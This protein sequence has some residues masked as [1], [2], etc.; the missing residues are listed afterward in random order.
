MRLAAV[1]ASAALFPWSGV[2]ASAAPQSPTEAAVSWLRDVASGKAEA[3]LGEETALSPEASPEDVKGVR[4]QL[5]RLRE[6]LKPDDLRPLAD[7][8]DGDLAA[9]LISQITNFDANSLQIHAVGLVRNKD[10][11]WVPAPMPSSFASTGLSLRP[12]FLERLKMM[13]SWMSVERSDQLVRLKADIF[14]LLTEE[15]RKVVTPATLKDSTPAKLATDFLTALAKRDMPTALALAGG[16]EDPRPANWDDTFQV[17]SSMLRRKEITHS[18]WRLL[19]APDAVRVI[20]QVDDNPAEPLVSIVGLDPAGSAATPRPRAVHLPLVRS[21]TGTWRVRLTHDLLAPATRPRSPGQ[22]DE[23]KDFD[24]EILAKFPAK[25]SE[26]MPPVPAATA[27][28]A[29]LA[30]ESALSK[31]SVAD[32]CTRLDLA[33]PPEVATATL[34]RAAAMWQRNHRRGD[35]L[36]AILVDVVESGDDA[37]AIFQMFSGRDTAKSAFERIQL[38]RTE[39]GWLA[40]AGFDSGALGISPENVEPLAKA[41]DAALDERRAEWWRGLITRIGGLAADSAPTEQDA[42]QVMTEFRQAIAARDA[43]TAIRLS[44][45]FDDD[46]GS[47]RLLRN[48]GNDIRDGQA[49]EILG[50]HRAGRWAAASL[51]VPPAPGDDSADAYRLIAIVATPAGPRVMPELDIYENLS[52]E[53]KRERMN[54]EVWDRISARLPEGARTELESIYEKHRSLSAADRGHRKTTE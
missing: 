51:R 50:I 29:A 44:A 40:N 19:A 11:Q 25:L 34:T 49:G 8:E 45:G 39:K 26:A 9:V 52:Q 43:A 46:L 12:G 53:R 6:S 23:D 15:M 1:I 3:K 4:S 24:A 31:D 36:S 18:L 7:K 2:L 35:G 38:R 41:L 22:E 28:D 14:S 5:A 20:V 32:L 48:L 47:S 42:R 13:E 21:K 37:F 30:I 17:I 16:L 54:G 33:N 27:R 10:G